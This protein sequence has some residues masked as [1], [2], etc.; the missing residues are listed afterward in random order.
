M[1]LL[2]GG[3]EGTNTPKC[4]LKHLGV[5][6][7]LKIYTVKLIQKINKSKLTGNIHVHKMVPLLVSCWWCCLCLFLWNL[8]TMSVTPVAAV[9]AT[10]TV[11]AEKATAAL[12]AAGA[13]TAMSDYNDDDD[14]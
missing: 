6:R 4:R 13:M 14:G 8:T 11:E 9:A 1:L 5:C 7:L 12:A 2:G 3:A 10:T